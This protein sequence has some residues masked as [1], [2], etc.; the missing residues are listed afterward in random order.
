VEIVP[1]GYPSKSMFLKYLK[2]FIIYLILFPQ[3]GCDDK[4][5]GEKSAYELL[6]SYES[7][8]FKGVFHELTLDFPIC[9]IE[10]HYNEIAIK[11]E[12]VYYCNSPKHFFA[13]DIISQEEFRNFIN[14][15]SL[16]LTS[17]FLEQPNDFLSD[18]VHKRL[19]T[20][21]GAR[22]S[23]LN[24]FKADDKVYTTVTCEGIHG[25]NDDEVLY[26]Y[27]YLPL[28][29]E[30]ILFQFVC[31]KKYFFELLPDFH[32]LLYNVEITNTLER[33]N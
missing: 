31:F 22:H 10:E 18:L 33:F 27:A 15:N 9:Y 1:T 24:L 16:K 13:L 20:L 6:S 25:N 23:E 3:T 12:H 32:R 2:Y 4:N 28:K 7:K 8:T 30:H 17:L 19:K 21:S 5:I 11:N 14:P 29:T 26:Y